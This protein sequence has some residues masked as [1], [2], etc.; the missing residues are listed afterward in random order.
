MR[1]H[2][3]HFSQLA[4]D[5]VLRLKGS[6]DL[7]RIAIIKKLGGALAESYLDDGFLLEKKVGVGQPKRVEDAR[8]LIANTAMDADR[9]KI[10]AATVRTDDTGEVAR[11]EQAE[12][13]RMYGKCDRIAQHGCNVFINRQLIYNLAEQ[14]FADHKIA[15]I[16]HADFDGV[17]R[18]ALVLGGDVV[19]TFDRP[20][21]VRLGRARLMEEIQIGESRLIRFSGCAGGEACSIVLRASSQHFLDEAERSMHDALCVLSQACRVNSSTVLGGGCSEALM[22]E[23]VEQSARATEGTMASGMDALCVALRRIPAILSDNAGYDTETLIQG[24]RAAHAQGKTTV[25][26]DMEKGQL[27]DMRQLGITESF[28]V[29]SQVVRSATEAAEMILRVDDIIRSAPRQREMDPRYA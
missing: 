13:D 25:G 1:Q 10:T 19:S 7:S 4:V 17:E 21:Q 3:E 23:C 28:L 14:Y 15:A 20:D 16:E 27:G 2:K 22:A 24:L 8:V 6:A 12:R 9:I 11:I 5:A 29:K 18:L 26:L